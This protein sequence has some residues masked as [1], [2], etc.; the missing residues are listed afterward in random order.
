MYDCKEV[1][2]AEEILKS[3]RNYETLANNGMELKN[4]KAGL[5]LAKDLKK[6]LGA[7]YKDLKKKKVQDYYFNSNNFQNYDGAITDAFVK[8]S[9]MLTYT[10]YFSFLY[11]VEYYMGYYIPFIK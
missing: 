9:G 3:M 4:K 2:S 10:N 8:T 7:E 11:D 6:M 1:P 5:E